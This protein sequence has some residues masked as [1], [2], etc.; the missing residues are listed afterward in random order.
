MPAAISAKVIK[1]C[2]WRSRGIT[3]VGELQPKGG[4]LGM[5][6]VAAANGRRVF[7][8]ERA[9]FQRGEKR[10]EIGEQQVC[11]FLQL[12]RESRVEYVARRHPLVQEAG[13]GADMLGEVG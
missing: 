10:V 13:F 6:A 7:V 4:R 12:H 5:N 3:W 1:N 2:A 9:P 8:L 11:G